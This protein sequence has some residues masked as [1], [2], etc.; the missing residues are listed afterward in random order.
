MSDLSSILSSHKPAIMGVL[1]LTE[2][3][4]S[5]GGRFLDPE[6]AIQHAKRLQKEGAHIIDIGAESTR[7]GSTGVSAK[8]EWQRLAPVLKA[9]RQDPSLCISVDTQKS[10]VIEKA[11]DLGVHMI[12][13]VNALSDP[14]AIALVAQSN[15]Y[16]CL[17]HMQGKPSNMQVDPLDGLAGWHHIIDALRTRVDLCLTQGVSGSKIV[18]DPGFGF[19]KTPRLNWAMIK[20]LPQLLDLGYPVLMGVSRKSTLGLLTGKPVDQRLIASVSSAAILA[21]QGVSVLR[22]HDVEET[23]DACLVAHAIHQAFEPIGE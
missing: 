10:Y 14:G 5:D 1:N 2:D 20:N 6:N 19:G 16:V 22:V 12:N 4:F 17:M 21:Y 9:L 7:P 11:L 13:S 18:L 23:R 15:A 3:S 8:E